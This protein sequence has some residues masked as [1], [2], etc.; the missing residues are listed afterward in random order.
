MVVRSYQVPSDVSISLSKDQK[1]RGSKV[2]VVALV[3]LS[4]DSQVCLRVLPW[5]Q[6]CFHPGP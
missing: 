6:A 5:R 1:P 3:C 4:G 2:T